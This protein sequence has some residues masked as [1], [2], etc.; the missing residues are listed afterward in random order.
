MPWP[1]SASAFLSNICTY[2]FK[3]SDIDILNKF[4]Y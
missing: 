2:T 1:Y 4:Y 3:I